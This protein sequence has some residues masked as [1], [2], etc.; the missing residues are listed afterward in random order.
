MSCGP[1]PERLG[2]LIVAPY[3]P[4]PVDFGGAARIYNLVR[5]LARQHDVVVVAPLAGDERDALTALGKICDV[6]A[7]PAAWSAR[8]AA[9]RR[10]RVQQLRSLAG[11]QSFQVR[12]SFS[13]QMQ[14]A[15][16]RLFLTRR[17]DVVQH[18]FPQMAL[19]QTPRPCPTVLDA[20]NVEYELLRRVAGSSASL[21]QR[22]F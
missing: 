1:M 6:T 5:Q 3:L 12:A 4:W 19:Y 18:E 17:I 10:K 8:Q 9:G 22:I 15:I 16:E 7:V 21:G 13:P 11:R 2:V 20:H 14:A